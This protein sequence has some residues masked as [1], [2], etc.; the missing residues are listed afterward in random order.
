MSAPTVIRA[1]AADRIVP[2]T[3]NRA[4]A[5][6]IPGAELVLMRRAG[7]LLPHRHAD[8][9]AEVIAEFAAGSR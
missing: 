4:L 5:D 8:R 3:A 1:G 7:H 2:A 6:Q 9:L